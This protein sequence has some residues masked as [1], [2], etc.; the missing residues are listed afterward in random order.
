MVVK[1]WV[2]CGVGIDNHCSKLTFIL[3]DNE[4][5]KFNDLGNIPIYSCNKKWL[6]YTGAV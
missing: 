5:Y 1:F 3:R 2:I 4:T 6:T